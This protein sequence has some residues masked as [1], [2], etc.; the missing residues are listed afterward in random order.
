[1]QQVPD[2]KSDA[3]RQAYY[4]LTDADMAIVKAARELRD[5]GVID[6]HPW[7]DARD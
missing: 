4:G 6:G 7:E 5:A 1:M 3:E 2:F